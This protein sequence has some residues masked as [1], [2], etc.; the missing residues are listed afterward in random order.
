[1]KKVLWV[2]FGW[3]EYYRGGPVV[4][5]FSWIKK[6]GNIAHEALNFEPATDGTYYCYVPPQGGEFAPK[7]DDSTGWT[8][9]CLAKYPDLQ[10]MHVVG[11]YENATLMGDWPN[12]PKTRTYLSVTNEDPDYG[13]TYC[14]TSKTAYL[15]PPKHRKDPI[16]HPSMGM[17]K[18]SYLVG[19]NLNE[20]TENQIEVL[21]ILESK[22]ADLRSV[23]IK[24]PTEETAPDLEVTPGDPLRSFGT[25]EHR[26]KVEKA[27]EKAVIKY[28]K[29]K[30]YSY[31]DV[32][33]KNCGYDFIFAKGKK[34][35]HVEVKGSSNNDG[36]FFMTPNEDSYR[37]HPQW[38]FALVSKALT[39]KPIVEV[40][41]NK[42]FNARFK[43]EPFVFQGRKK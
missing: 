2:K 9:V 41:S 30:G 43:L 22:L 38:R 23:A 40:L 39:A 12:V 16:S 7:N 19:P 32:T 37:E 18:Y 17:A 10:G 36:R 34:K 42:N 1:M 8:V 24:N 15:V 5:A 3:S 11:W 35:L 33:K 28:Y 13:W 25:P 14:I 6:V 20:R 21:D 27:G 31:T 4:G 29:A 26:K